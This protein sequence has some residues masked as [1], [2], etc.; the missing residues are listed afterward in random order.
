MFFTHNH[1]HRARAFLF[2]PALVLGHFLAVLA[3]SEGEDLPVSAREPG[4]EV[5]LG[6]VQQALAALRVR[7]STPRGNP[8]VV[9]HI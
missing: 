1:L 3:A 2:V 9:V 5:L 6:Q 8:D 4:K 7:G